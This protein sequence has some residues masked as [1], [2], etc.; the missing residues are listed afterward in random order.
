MR[1]QMFLTGQ[2]VGTAA[3]MSV[4][5]GVKPSEVDVRK[6]RKALSEAGF[7]MGDSKERL[8]ELGLV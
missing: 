5:D 1:W 3:A 6:L 2:V 7:Y 4:E 8:S